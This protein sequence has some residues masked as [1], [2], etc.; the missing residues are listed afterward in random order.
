MPTE[1]DI[2]DD[3]EPGAPIEVGLKVTPP[4]EGRPDAD[5]EIDELKLPSAVVE[6][7]VLPLLRLATVTEEGD[8]LMEKSGFS[9]VTVSVTVAV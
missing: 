3:P 9:P 8:A 4:P 2:V 1:I 6:I 7:V 5:R